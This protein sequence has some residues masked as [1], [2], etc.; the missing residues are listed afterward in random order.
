MRKIDNG[1]GNVDLV[2]ELIMFCRS[3]SHMDIYPPTVGCHNNSVVLHYC[4]HDSVTT[5]VCQS[6]Q[7]SG[8]S[9]SAQAVGVG[10][11]FVPCVCVCVCACPV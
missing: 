8:L 5:V 2:L 10:R 11:K 3:V 9:Y 7:R 6:R 4:H 1:K